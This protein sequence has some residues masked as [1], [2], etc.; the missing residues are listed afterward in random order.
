MLNFQVDR[1]INQKETSRKKLYH[2]F[3]L[4]LQIL[5]VSNIFLATL[6]IFQCKRTQCNEMALKIKLEIVFGVK[7]H[8]NCIR[9]RIAN[10][11]KMAQHYY[12]K[13]SNFTRNDILIAVDMLQQLQLKWRT[14]C[15][16]NCT[17]IALVNA[18]FLHWKWHWK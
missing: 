6:I 11:V 13:C 15:A 2:R 17:V 9:N 7:W 1:Q 5:I 3:P 10:V 18:W 16:R 4:N 14:K 8:Y 12:K